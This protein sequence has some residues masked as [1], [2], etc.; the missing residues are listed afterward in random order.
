VRK[1]KKV[2]PTPI[3]TS[4]EQAIETLGLSRKIEQ[5]TAVELWPTIVGER[6]AQVTV[7]ERM[8]DNKL[9]VHVTQAP[10]RNELTFL[11]KDIIRKI[12]LALGNDLVKD[13]IFR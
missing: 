9:F 10:W 7:A 6:I 1:A 2:R 5:Y 13:I 8:N 12:N 3:K 11:K 4:I